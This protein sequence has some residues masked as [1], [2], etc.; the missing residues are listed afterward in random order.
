MRETPQKMQIVTSFGTY[1]PNG[2]LQR[3]ERTATLA[4][5]PWMFALG[6]QYDFIR[7]GA[8]RFGIVATATQKLW[9]LYRSRQ[10][11][12]PQQGYVWSNTLALAFGLRHVHAGGLT[13]FVDAA[14]EPTPVPLQTGRTNYVDNDRYAI[15]AGLNYQFA[16]SG[17][18]LKLRLGLQGQVHILRDR[19]QMKI[20]PTVAPY[21]GKNY[22]QL[23]QDEWV[24][25][26]ANNRGE[27]IAQSYGLQTN[28]PGWPG[29]SSRGLILGAGVNAALLY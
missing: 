15:A 19:E 12:R 10:N 5:E 14:Y 26:A 9:S 1:L 8:H 3:A 16:I 23:V 20:D 6:A 28:N 25:G 21:A 4:W 22:S 27:V 7:R 13:L 11:E 17:S 24:D 2:D 18:K 29:F